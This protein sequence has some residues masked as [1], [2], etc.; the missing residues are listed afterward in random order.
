D[1]LRLRDTFERERGLARRFRAVNLDHASARQAANPQ[2]QIQAERAGWNDRD[3]GVNALLAEFHY[4]ALAELFLDLAERQ[5]E[6]L[7]LDILSH[8]KSPQT[9]AREQRVAE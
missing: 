7:A 2:R 5:I 1:L 3:V 6:R 9:A 4:R 8:Q